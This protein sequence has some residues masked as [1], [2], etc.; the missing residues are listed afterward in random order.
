LYSKAALHEAH[1]QF[2]QQDQLA[3]QQYATSYSDQLAG[4]GWN[5][6]AR[7]GAGDWM[8][9]NRMAGT[10]GAAAQDV[11]DQFN[12]LSMG[13]TPYVTQMTNMR[14]DFTN[15]LGDVNRA[16]TDFSNQRDLEA[17]QYSANIEA[18]RKK[19]LRAAVSR[20]SQT[21]GINPVQ[22]PSRGGTVAVRNP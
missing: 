19:A 10:Y 18:E 16:K 1:Q 3:R 22:I 17:K 8:T 21:Y 11:S 5:P 20:I 6:R 9:S 4:L 7:S 14:N 13:G 2:G 12:F 15:R